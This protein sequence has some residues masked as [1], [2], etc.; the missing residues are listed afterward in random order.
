M[1]GHVIG[2]FVQ[3][4]VLPSEWGSESVSSISRCVLE[5]HRVEEPVTIPRR[6]TFKF[7]QLLNYINIITQIK[8][9]DTIALRPMNIYT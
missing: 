9:N 8:R 7:L 4:P 6:S 5:T 2:G 3:P 1:I